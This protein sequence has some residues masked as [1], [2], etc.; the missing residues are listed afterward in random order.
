MNKSVRKISLINK[1]F[2]PFLT[3]LTVLTSIIHI[4]P[5]SL[6]ELTICLLYK[7]YRGGM[8]IFEVRTVREVSNPDLSNSYN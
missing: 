7:T 4:P 5:Y 2:M 8:S 1:G 6:A 3:V